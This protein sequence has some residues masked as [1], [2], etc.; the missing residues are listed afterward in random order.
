MTPSPDCVRTPAEVKALSAAELPALAEALRA[1]MLATVS[2]TGGH[3]A[4]SL[5]AVELAIGLLR[6]FDPER[7]R[8]VWDVG[9]QTYAWK[10]LTGRRD[11]FRT[12]RSFDGLSGFCNPEETACDAFVS[13]HAGN[14]L[15]AA[16]G[17]VAARTLVGGDWSVVAV[18]GEAAMTNGESLEA[19][20]FARERTD[21]LVLVV[22]DNAP[23]SHFD[24][25]WFATFGLAYVGPVDGHDA[26]AVESALRTAQEL[27]RR[28]A[29]HVRTVKGKGFPPAERNPTAWHGVGPFDRTKA[30]AGETVETAS[31][32]A[33]SWS[34]AF[35]AALCEL[36]RKDARVCALTAAMPNG[37]GLTAF[38]QEFQARFFDVGICESLLVTFAAGLA[39]AGRRPV[40][41][42]YSAFLQRAVDQVMHDVCLLN[43]PVVF[44][45]DHAGCVGADGR[46]HHGMFDIPMLRCLPNLTILQPKD[47]DELAAMLEMA[48]A[49]D[50]PVA[51]RYPKGPVPAG[52]KGFKGLN[53]FNGLKGGNGLNG[54][55]GDR[56]LKDFNG[57][58]DLNGLKGEQLVRPEALLQLWALGDQVPKAL[59]V[60]RILGEQG[61]SAGVVNARLV[62]PVDV[63]L[64][65]RQVAAGAQ[66][67]TLE[68]GALAGGFGSAVQEALPGVPIVRFGWP[69][70]FVAQGTLDELEA[71]HGLTAQQIADR[72]CD[73]RQSTADSWTTDDNQATID[74]RQ[75]TIRRQSTADSRPTSD[76]RLTTNDEQLSTFNF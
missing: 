41:A 3:L 40:V 26:A 5:G 51:I 46:T 55:K 54:F 1:E 18:V 15:A 25:R 33:Q 65:R 13:G 72:L 50:G 37:T 11:R 28:V 45:I 27:R 36:A 49:H 43:L 70:T 74:N 64:L 59:E 63:E 52:F 42:V 48:L 31:A 19:L 38:A 73:S 61:I 30:A 32:A 23:E 8:I 10:L 71:A 9:H 75:P 56:G 29:V 2:R 62:K 47:A 17:L 16:E 76:N 7:D 57:V 67:V 22:N 58:R 24:A 39:K 20:A 68:N 44:A 69:D 66:I 14:A 34:E 35:G 4:S 12:L 21:R 60:A 53:G 6:V